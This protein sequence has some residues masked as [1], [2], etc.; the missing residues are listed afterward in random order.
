MTNALAGEQA[1]ELNKE[2]TRRAFEAL[3]TGDVTVYDEIL[4]PDFVDHFPQPG[5]PPGPE[6]FKQAV[7]GFRS[8]FPD[9]NCSLD[10]II[11]EGDKVM[12]RTTCTGTQVGPMPGL[13]P[14]DRLITMNGILIFRIVDGRIVERWGV[15]DLMG[16]LLLPLQAAA[17]ASS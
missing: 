8:I 1:I 5:Q 13:P 10:D 14:S 12:F 16:A 15:S 4:A 3:N 6:G 7:I 17:A 9:I 2:I 11:A